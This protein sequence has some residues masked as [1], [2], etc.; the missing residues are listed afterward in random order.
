MSETMNVSKGARIEGG[1]DAVVIGAT[2]D[3]FA[4][5]AMIARSGLHVVLIETGDRPREKRE[6]S[7]GYF[8]VDGDPL[9]YALDQQVID[10][11]D[12]YRHGLSFIARRLET[13]VR[14]GDGAAMT[15]PGDPALAGEAVAAFSE[16]D[17]T[18]FADFLEEE[19]KTARALSGWFSGGAAPLI[20]ALREIGAASFDGAV[21]GRFADQ[22]LEDYLRAEVSIGA[23]HRSSEAYTYLALL[24]R[25]AGETAGLQ[26][27]VAAIDG[28][29]RGL[30]GALRRAAQAAG[31]SIR[32]TDRVR[33]VIVEWDRVAGVSFDDGGQIRA[34]VIVSALSARETFIDFVGKARLDIEFAR[35]LDFPAPAIATVRAHLALN[36]PIGDALVGARLDRRFLLAPSAATLESA[37]RAAASGKASN[38]VVELVFPSALDRT[39]AP[40]GCLTAAMLLHPVAFGDPAEEVWREGIENVAREAIRRVAPEMSAEIVAIDLD[41]PERAAPPMFEAL[42]RRRRITD[43]SG[44]EGYFFCGPE[45]SI[46]GGV[47]LS[48][49]RRAGERALRYFKE[50]GTN[51]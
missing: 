19:R 22:R 9:A 25:L 23:A 6:F 36:G 1:I 21:I 38:G 35:L 45:A 20:P 5:A 40:E 30:A 43:A 33:T 3:A 48:A 17:A 44:L 8:A 47:S 46:G 2:A 31:V 13:F 10:A 29:G 42:E 12:L 15:L 49:G 51:P 27:G 16:A 18:R 32:Q 37:W 7:P 39:L 41:A 24:R 50:G 4:A 28:G 11:L 34:P 26:G 14:F